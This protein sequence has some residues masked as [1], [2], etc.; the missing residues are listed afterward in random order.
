[1]PNPLKS[2][3]ASLSA[4]ENIR[5]VFKCHKVFKEQMKGYMKTKDFLFTGTLL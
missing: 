2:N 4:F 5:K 3:L 1:M